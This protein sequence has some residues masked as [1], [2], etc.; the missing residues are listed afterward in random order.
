MSFEIFNEKEKMNK[1][2]MYFIKFF[3]IYQSASELNS[4]TEGKIDFD[5]VQNPETAKT[6]KVDLR[7]QDLKV[8]QTKLSI[9]RKKLFLAQSLR[10]PKIQSKHSKK[11]KSERKNNLM[12]NIWIYIWFY[13]LRKN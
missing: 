13:I 7:T 10:Y 9:K 2:K 4:D 11:I 12:N 3:L 1:I 8:L 6:K 5:Q